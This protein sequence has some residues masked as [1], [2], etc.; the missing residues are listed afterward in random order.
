MQLPVNRFKQALKDGRMQWGIW[1]TFG[2]PDMAELLAAS[3]YDWVLIDGEHGAF[4]VG[5]IRPCLQA[6]AGYPD[7]SP[8]VRLCELDTALIKRNLDQGAQTLMV[9][10]INTAAEARAAVSAMRFAPEGTRGFNSATRAGRYGAIADYGT[11]AKD[12]LCLIVQLES[13]AALG[14]LEE[15]AAVEGV[16]AVFIGPADLA[17]DMGYPGNLA[18]PEVQDAV[19]DAIARLKALGMP[20]GIFTLDPEMQRRAIAAGASFNALG[21]DA[22]MLMQAAQARLAQFRGA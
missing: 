4:D 20:A 1:Q 10:M 6:V 3:G 2:G 16:D 9:P 18:A 11:R 14:N 15:I 22:L 12:E 17:A 13:R 21:L 19:E 8:V 7:C 5:E